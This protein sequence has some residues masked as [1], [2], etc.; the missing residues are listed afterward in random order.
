MHTT[1]SLNWMESPIAKEK[2]NMNSVYNSS[3]SIEHG[4][5]YVNNDIMLKNAVM[6]CNMAIHTYY[7][8]KT[9]MEIQTQSNPNWP[10]AVNCY[11]VP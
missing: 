10:L 8:Y 3:N 6:Y 4:G 9:T 5:Y 1:A 11:T 7:G 2:Q